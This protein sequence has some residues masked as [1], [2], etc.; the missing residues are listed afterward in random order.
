[1]KKYDVSVVIS[2]IRT[3][4]WKRIIDQLKMSCKRHT[5]EVIFVSTK[6]LPDELKTENNIKH[7]LDFGCPSRC[8]QLATMSSEAEMLAAVSDDCII[9]EDALDSAIEDLKNS[10]DPKKNIVALR[11][12]EGPNFVADQNNFS[13]A[14][15]HAKTHADLRLAGIEDHWKICLMFLINTNRYKE[16]GGIDC[17]FEHFNMNLHDLAFRNQRDGADV[18]ISTH[19][20][21]AHDWN[22]SANIHNSPMVQ[23]YH[24]N[25]YPLFHSIYSSKEA[26]NK[27]EIK[28]DYNNWMQADVV[29]KRRK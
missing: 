24:Y 22:P 7:M 15:W 28:I 21:T 13:P 2:G 25:D 20:V 23:A 17:R 6:P 4:N 10:N 9:F 27:R 12:T 1:M 11:Y 14:Y 3:E 8:L 19:F 5:Y 18:I 29:W 16:L 26:A